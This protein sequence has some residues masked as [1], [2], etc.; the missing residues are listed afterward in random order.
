MKF[1][2]AKDKDNTKKTSPVSLADTT[3]SGGSSSGSNSDLHSS[4]RSQEENQSKGVIVGRVLFSVCLVVLIS[5]IG[6]SITL[7]EK[8]RKEADILKAAAQYDV[9]MNRALASIERLMNNRLAG[10]LSMA[11]LAAFNA[12]LAEQWPLVHVDSWWT[13]GKTVE[14]AGLNG[15]YSLAPIVRPENISAFEEYA[16]GWLEKTYPG[17][18]AGT[19]SFGFGIWAKNETTDSPD[20]KY[21]L[22]YGYPDAYVSQNGFSTPKFQ[23]TKGNHRLLM[24]DVHAF[25]AQGKSVDDA[26]ACS[27]VR[28]E[29]VNYKDN[30]CQALSDLVPPKDPTARTGPGAFVS[31]CVFPVE[32][33]TECVA[34][35][36][37]KMNIYEVLDDTFPASVEGIDCIVDTKFSSASYRMK[38]GQAWYQGDQDVHD[39]KFQGMGRSAALFQGSNLTDGSISYDITC[40]PTDEFYKEFESS[41]PVGLTIGAA[42]LVACLC[43]CFFL[44]DYLVRQEFQ[45]KK[46]LLKAKRQFVRFVSHEVRTPLNSVCMALTLL[47]EEIGSALGYNTTEELEKL[48]RKVEENSK[49]VGVD[50]ENSKSTVELGWFKLAKEV[51]VNAESSVEVL[52]DL[53]NYD[54]VESGSLSLELTAIPIWNTIKQTISEFRLPAHS[55]N[56]SL[57]LNLPPQ[58]LPATGSSSEMPLQDAKVVGDDIRLVQVIRN[59]VSNALKFT[60]EGKAVNINVHWRPSPSPTKDT[61]TKDVNRTFKLRTKEAVTVQQ[62]GEIVC[63]VEDE[64]AGLSAEQLSKLFGVGVQFNVNELQKGNGSGLGLFIAKGIIEQHE[65]SLV[66]D[67]AGL[68]CGTSFT[69]T[70]PLYNIPDPVQENPDTD[71]QYQSAYKQTPLNILVVDDA[72]SNRKLLKRLLTK[73][74]N[75]CDEAENGQEAVTIVKENASK[76]GLPYDLILLDYEMPVMNGPTAAKKIRALSQANGIEQH[77][78]EASFIVGITGNFM[79]EDVE[80]FKRCGANAVLPKPFKIQELENLCAEYHVT[81]NIEM[82]EE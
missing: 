35:V 45:S 65:G 72:R 30:N 62:C 31:T 32:D 7:S 54:K 79:D 37:A 64:G 16:Q 18:G 1:F 22:T 2:E 73:R 51:Q 33:S 46:A 4:I 39:S 13:I 15:G 3:R 63:C 66:C 38:D 76:G 6:A 26:Y 14:V 71:E 36:F 21:H 48:N 27:K 77:S 17:E 50:D 49:D 41:R 24:L 40:Y 28:A 70:L 74:G 44:Y 19:S 10:A 81:G 8:N 56:I 11:N 55:K 25:P 82:D 29:Q 42:V 69:V 75:T 80:Y 68:G 53:L 23:H 57:T 47:Q 61:A 9:I 67:S 59:L 78:E 20:N 34:M 60:P 52:N 12:P 58:T 43:I 5:I